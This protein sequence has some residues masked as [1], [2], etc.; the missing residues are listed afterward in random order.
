MPCE[1]NR[2]TS[3]E[4]IQLISEIYGEKLDYFVLKNWM[5]RILSL[6]KAGMRETIELLYLYKTDNISDST[7]FSRR[8][9]EYIVTTYQE[10]MAEIIG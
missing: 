8:F 9:P 5:I 1:N 10:G 2:L 7:K 3:K 4:F 6:F